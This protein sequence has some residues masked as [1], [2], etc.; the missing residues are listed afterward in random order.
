MREWIIEAKNVPFIADGNDLEAK[1]VLALK[2]FGSN[3]TLKDKKVRGE[4]IDVWS[5]LRADPTGRRWERDREVESLSLPWEGSV[6]P[7]N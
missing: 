5:A 7:F 3:L 6:R 2:I 1:R 4:G